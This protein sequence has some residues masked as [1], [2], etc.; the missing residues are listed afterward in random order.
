MGNCN[1][2]IRDRTEVW[3]N[4]PGGVVK[5]PGVGN[6][7]LP[8][9]LGDNSPNYMQQSIDYRKQFYERNKLISADRFKSYNPSEKLRTYQDRPATQTDKVSDN[10]IPS[11]SSIL[12]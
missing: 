11:Y 7:K 1:T 12:S 4:H 2:G 6:A 10:G 5:I 9:F 8:E 3:A